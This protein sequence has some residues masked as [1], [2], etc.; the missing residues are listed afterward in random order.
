MSAISEIPDYAALLE[1][2]PPK[3]LRT[4]EE[5]ERCTQVLRELD[6]RLD[7]L[8]VG[9]K[10]YAELLTLLIEDFEQRH[11]QLPQATP[12]SVLR[13]LMEEHGLMQKD[14]ASIFGAPSI[15]SE[16]LSGKR[17]MNTEHIRRLS[18][19]FHVSPEVFF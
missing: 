13:F 4:E 5:N 17:E 11:Y 16:V 15:V 9:E 7:D 6:G 2:F 3:I 19:R 12:T 14:L 10:E 8:T 18:E 1:R